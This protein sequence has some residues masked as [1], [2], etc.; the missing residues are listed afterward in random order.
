MTGS[1]SRPTGSP[2]L[3][4]RPLAEPLALLETLKEQDRAAVIRVIDALLTQARMRDLLQ[5]SAA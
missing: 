4:D 3:E 1:M 5:Q 2:S